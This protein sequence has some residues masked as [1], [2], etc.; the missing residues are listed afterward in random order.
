MTTLLKKKILKMLKK[1][2]VYVYKL[3]MDDIALT[4]TILFSIF[5]KKK[6]VKKIIT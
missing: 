3:I 1:R 5:K 4:L 2:L 6:E